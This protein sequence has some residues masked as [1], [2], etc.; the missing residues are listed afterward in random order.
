MTA[1]LRED[2]WGAAK[3]TALATN[4]L[5]GA[6][7]L[8]VNAGGLGTWGP[9]V[10]GR[11]T[12]IINRGKADE[13]K[14][15][16]TAISGDSLTGLIRGQD[17]TADQA[18]A[19]GA[20]VEHGLFAVHIDRPNEFLSSPTAAG[21]VP[22]STGADNWGPPTNTL[23][24]MTLTNPTM[25]SPNVGST[26][27]GDAQ[28][29]HSGPTAGGL[30]GG[31]VPTDSR[32]GDATVNGTA[33][34]YATADHKHSREAYGSVT[35]SAVTDAAVTGVA[36]SLSRSD[37][38]HGREGFGAATTLSTASAKTDGASPQVNRADHNH[39]WPV[40]APLG[41]GHLGTDGYRRLLAN[42]ATV[43]AETVIA[44]LELPFNPGGAFGT[45]RRLRITFTARLNTTVAN[46]LVRVRIRQAASSPVTT[47][48]TELARGQRALPAAG[49]NGQETLT[50][51][52]EG[53][54]TGPVVFGVTLER[55]AGGGNVSIIA[56]TTSPAWLTIEDLGLGS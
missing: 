47:A 20:T 29:M 56:E 12:V 41:Q 40:T 8:S 22:V 16:A 45:S 44:D 52:A 13:E 9:V 35:N 32:P 4:L 15:Y 21:Q 7:S 34:A 17:G 24:N 43:T 27:W 3:P 55:A 11:F 2:L 5:A 19:P 25:T 39:G 42:S 31:G 10:H 18:H 46:D 48:S 49:G 30:L 6:T 51:F 54:F 36:T 53:T 26:E 28:H 14:L 1:V 33:G 50:F 23:A 38:K 37:H